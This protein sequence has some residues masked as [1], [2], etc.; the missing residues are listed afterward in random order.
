[1]QR[2]PDAPRRA[3]RIEPRRQFLGAARRSTRRTAR[4]R[5][6]PTR[7][8][9]ISSTYWRYSVLRSATSIT[10]SSTSSTAAGFVA[11]IACKMRERV[12]DARKPE[13]REA[14]APSARGTSASSARNVTASVPSAAADEVREIHA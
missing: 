3:E 7:A 5:A 2:L 8:F 4:R 13:D 14:R 1:M 6:R 9:G 11:S 12:A 10:T